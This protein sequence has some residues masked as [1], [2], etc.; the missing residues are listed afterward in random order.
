[1]ASETVGSSFVSLFL[2]VTDQWSFPPVAFQAMI[3]SV[4]T[5]LQRIANSTD[6]LKL[7]Y[8]AIAYK[9][10]LSLFNMTGVVA[11]GALPPAIGAYPFLSPHS[12][13][14]CTYLRRACA[15]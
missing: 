2:E 3:P 8:S 7:H 15:Q 13:S 14:T 11:D 6:P 4:V 1:M 12:T 10:F 5:A 9:P